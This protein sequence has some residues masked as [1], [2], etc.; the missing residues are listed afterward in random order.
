M[1]SYVVIR[2]NAVRGLNRYRGRG[3]VLW[4]IAVIRVARISIKRSSALP[5]K[6]DLATRRTDALT[7]IT[8]GWQAGESCSSGGRFVVNVHT[9]P[10]ALKA[11]GL[12]AE[13]EIEANG[14]VSAETS[15][16]LACDA[17]KDHAALGSQCLSPRPVECFA[18]QPFC[19]VGL[20]CDRCQ[21]IAEGMVDAKDDRFGS[22]GD[23]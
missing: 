8:E 1:A 9:D 10:E 22:A 17:A 21:F 4:P 6:A 20:F 2:L 15:R 13:A 12:G 23:R 5:L 18:G 3:L 19:S 7:R 16:R 11:G 14:K